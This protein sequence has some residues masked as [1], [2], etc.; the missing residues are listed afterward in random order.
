MAK[1][2]EEKLEPVKQKDWKLLLIMVLSTV[3]LLL[4]IGAGAYYLGVQSSAGNSED[5]EARDGDDKKSG[6]PFGSPDYLGPLVELEEFVVNITDREKTRYL[7][8]SMTLEVE[9]KKTKS[10][11]DDRLP[12]VRDA[13]IFQLSGKTYDQL[14]D[15]QGKKQLQ[16]ELIASLNEILDKG[17]IHSIYFTE[18]VVQ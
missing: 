17:R 2:R 18:F 8:I 5:S 10:E 12:Q 13:I 14:R 4:A 1:N 6:F 15:L 9:N 11:I 7:K 16:A 3:L